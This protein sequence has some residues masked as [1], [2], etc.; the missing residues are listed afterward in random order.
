MRRP[1]RETVALGAIALVSAA[2]ALYT[3]VELL[4]YH[5]LNHDEGVYLQQA[6]LLLDGRLWFASEVPEAFRWWFFVEDGARLYPK[7]APVPP[8]VFALAMALGE[9]RLALAFVAFANVFLVGLLTAEAFDRRVGVVAGGVAAA[10]PL[11]VVQS[12]TFLPYA[13][14]TMFNL[15]F[16]L[17]Y[18]RSVRRDSLG[19]AAFAGVALGLAFFSRPYTAVLFA[20]PFVLHAMYALLDAALEEKYDVL[21]RSFGRNALLAVLG[22]AGVAT[23]LYYNSLTTGDPFVFPYQ[24]FAPL[25]GLGFG[26]RRILS[27]DRVYT[28]ALAL[29][30]NGRVVFAYLTRWAFAPPVGP[31]VA[32]LGLVLTVGPLADVVGPRAVARRADRVYNAYDE[33]LRVTFAAV[34]VTVT[35]GNVLFWGNLNVLADLPDPNDGLIAVLG[36][37][38]HFDLLL[39][40]SAFTAAGLVVSWRRLREAA[41]EGDLSTR[42]TRVALGVLLVAG[43]AV[44]GVTTVG[45]LDDPVE[46]H[47]TYTDRYEQAYAPFQSR[48]GGDW[49][50]GPF[51]SDPA[52]EDALVFVPNPYGDW[53]GHPFQSLQNDGDL[54]GPVVYALDRGPDEDFAVLDAHPDRDL[55]RYTYRGPWTPDPRPDVVASIQRLQV[56]QGSSHAI[57]TTVGVVGEPSSV[58]L[59]VGDRAAVYDVT[60][61][62]TGNLTVP[63]SVQPGA[64]RVTGD[65]FVPR[66]DGRVGYDG[67][68][69]VSLAVTFVQEGG[70]TVTYRQ[71]ATVRETTDGVAL[72]WPPETRVCRLTPDCGTEATYLGDAGGEYLD[73]VSVRALTTSGEGNATS[74]SVPT[75]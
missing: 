14:T 52:F 18:V 71:E 49:E 21:V 6:R 37:F 20:L 67:A 46:R 10:T 63:W 57:R 15:A 55:Y 4:P 54:R 25:D 39:P 30:A 11:F 62:P 44:A 59:E 69:E 17:G 36:P 51:G 42:D 45:A 3:S 74:A 12:A 13:T 40:F 47:A 41:E 28:P 1:P 35:A 34:A 16:A 58:R 7:Y 75:R 32:L 43:L 19:Y 70:A 68:A 64:A 24:A 61:D 2:L 56:Q 73:G 22:L 65:G 8:G 5:S 38:Y 26:E 33:T 29:E 66:G 9:A 50:R 48:A 72:V 31:V 53:L 23:A 60:A 27:Y